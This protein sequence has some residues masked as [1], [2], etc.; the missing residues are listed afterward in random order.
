MNSTNY[1]HMQKNTSDKCNKPSIKRKQHP[2]KSLCIQQLD[3]SNNL[4]DRQQL[5][6]FTTVNCLSDST[7]ISQRP[8]LINRKYNAIVVTNPPQLDEYE[9]IVVEQPPVKQLTVKP[10]VKQLA[11]ISQCRFMNMCTNVYCN[12]SHPSESKRLCNILEMYNVPLPPRPNK[13]NKS[14]HQHAVQY[15]K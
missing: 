15:D 5:N 10:S 6:T 2:K 14:K 11:S 1:N 7:N 9:S 13:S 3:C 4:T 12:F 8:Y